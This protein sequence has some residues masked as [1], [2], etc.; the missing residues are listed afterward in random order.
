MD[1]AF[2][3]REAELNPL[4]RVHNDLDLARRPRHLG[5]VLDGNR[6]WARAQKFG[7]VSDGHRIGFGKIPEVLSWCD[8]RGIEFVTLWMLSTDNVRN[9]SQTELEA[10]YEIDEDIVRKLIASQRFRL[11]LLG[12]AEMLPDR[13]TSVLRMA[14]EET[15]NLKG[16]QVNLAIAYGGRED[17]M[18]SIHSLVA[19]ILATG[20][21]RITLERLAAHLSTAGQPDPDLIIRT[22]GEM[23][24]SGFLLWQAALAEFYFC[25]CYWPDFSESELDNAL[26]AYGG[27]N[28]RFGA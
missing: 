15:A 26:S 14:E 16:M 20:D 3:A 21:R 12:C 23:R 18:R 6:R 1:K 22:S 11:R 2:L 28:R 13:L 17:L 19:D 8:A 7:D 4:H 27:R 25:D 10:L 24:M 5:I 9:R